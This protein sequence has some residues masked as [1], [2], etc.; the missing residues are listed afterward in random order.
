MPIEIA[1]ENKAHAFVPDWPQAA[2]AVRLRPPPGGW[3]R[4]QARIWPGMWLALARADDAKLVTQRTVP[5]D[6]EDLILLP[7]TR[8]DGWELVFGY[9]VG[10]RFDEVSDGSGGVLD[11]IIQLQWEQIRGPELLMNLFKHFDAMEAWE[12]S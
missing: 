3:T 5:T 2:F 10:V 7:I 4:E 12:E 9:V 6:I 1:S 8:T 11:L